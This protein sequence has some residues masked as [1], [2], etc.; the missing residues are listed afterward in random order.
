MAPLG[1]IEPQ[2]QLRMKKKERITMGQLIVRIVMGLGI[3]G[4]F[5]SPAARADFIP[6]SSPVAAYLNGTTRLNV[7]QPDFSVVS[8]LSD[9]SETATFSA[10]LVALTVPTTWSTW[11]SPPNTESATPR[12]L[13]TNGL[14]S[15]RIDLSSPVGTFGLE[16]EPGPIG[17]FNIT[18][19]FFDSGGLVGTIT[20]SVNGNAGALLFA[21]STTTTSFNRVDLSSSQDF[22]IANLRYTSAANVP[23]PSTV[24]LCLIGGGVLVLFRSRR[25]RQ[26]LHRSL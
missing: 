19:S 9:A 13:W 18:A 21:A 20:R 7:V 3:L 15:L 12:V 1:A 25:S 6:I 5:L 16:A 26:G 10:G 14:T 24:T 2:P 4:V 8:S 17:A 23:E 22:A 11:G